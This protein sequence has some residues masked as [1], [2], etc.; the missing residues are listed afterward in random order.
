M[1][2]KNVDP[3][4]EETFQKYSEGLKIPKPFRQRRNVM[5]DQAEWREYTASMR[6]AGE[7][8]AASLPEPNEQF[9]QEFLEETLEQNAGFRTS[10]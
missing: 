8:F 7:D 5:R 3:W 6:E 9:G 4:N 2:V 10:Y 1:F